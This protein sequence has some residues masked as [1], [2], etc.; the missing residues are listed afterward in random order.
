MSNYISVKVFNE[1]ENDELWKKIASGRYLDEVKKKAE[2]V[3]EELR[4]LEDD[5][6]MEGSAKK[7]DRY[8]RLSELDPDLSLLASDLEALEESIRSK[9][10][11]SL[12][13]NVES[14]YLGLGVMEERRDST[15]SDSRYPFHDFFSLLF[16][17]VLDMNVEAQFEDTFSLVPTETWVELYRK[18][19]GDAVKNAILGLGEDSDDPKTLDY[20]I[21]WVTSV[22]DLVKECL[23]TK[24]ELR[25]WDEFYESDTEI[26]TE[27]EEVAEIIKKYFQF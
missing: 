15:I 3:H 1:G 23:E 21:E 8:N 22:R 9:N 12:E 26:D 2:A 20:Y 10:P 19:D 4:G 11:K 13:K 24:S 14:V 16:E 6:M 7:I 27:K 17:N 5:P 18:I 25:I